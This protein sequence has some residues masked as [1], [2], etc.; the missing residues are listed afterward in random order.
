[1]YLREL[2]RFGTSRVHACDLN[3]L[4]FLSV[5]TFE[6]HGD[7]T[8]DLWRSEYIDGRFLDLGIVGGE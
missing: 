1:M 8:D 7:S 3:F 6:I 2:L 5:T 4:L